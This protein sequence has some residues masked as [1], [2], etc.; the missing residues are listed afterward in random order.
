MAALIQRS[1]GEPDHLQQP[2]WPAEVS[3]ALEEGWV[4]RPSRAMVLNYIARNFNHQESDYFDLTAYEASVNQIYVPD[5]GIDV[6]ADD[7]Q[8]A[9]ARR[10]YRL[11][12]ELLERIDK[13]ADPRQFI[14]Y[15]NVGIG[16]AGKP[17]ANIH[18]HK[19][20]EGERPWARI[21]DLEGYADEAVM[22]VRVA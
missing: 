2:E 10:G 19:V 6:T 20:H 21:D 22:V 16:Y 1:E 7:A 14:A 8:A 3:N 9:L 5:E 13:V 18:I 17:G 11:V 12:Q 15:L 4:E